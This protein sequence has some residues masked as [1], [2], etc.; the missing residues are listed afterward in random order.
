MLVR[1]RS[2]ILSSDSNSLLN[3]KYRSISTSWSGRWN[4]R[5][6]HIEIRRFVGSSMIF[7]IAIE[8]QISRL[9][10]NRS[11]P[12]GQQSRLP[13]LFELEPELFRANRL[14]VTID[15]IDNDIEYLLKFGTEDNL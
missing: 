1:F 3:R 15:P 6:D 9:N 10:P 7:A 8:S 12:R 11:S 14:F 5:T 4:S 13:R 2:N